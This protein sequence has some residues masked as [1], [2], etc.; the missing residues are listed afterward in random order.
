MTLYKKSVGSIGEN[1]AS[2]Y[3]KS[4]GFEILYKN[5]RSKYG[6]IDIIAEKN[7]KIHFVEVKTRSSL[8]KGAP[9]EAVNY[10]KIQHL[11][12]AAYYF[13]K[14]NHLQKH[15]LSVDVASILLSRDN[16]VSDFKYFESVDI[17][18]R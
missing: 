10:R 8:S 2:D 18:R 11:K 9:Y 4:N 3:L 14:Q 16:R 15:K 17:E 6:E 1:I 13:I 12:L 7:D 5:F